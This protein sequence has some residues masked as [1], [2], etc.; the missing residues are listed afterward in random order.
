[1]TEWNVNFKEVNTVAEKSEFGKIPV[2]GFDFYVYE[3][4]MPDVLPT[5][6]VVMLINMDKTPEGLT[7]VQGAEVNAPSVDRPFNLSFTEYAH[8][9]TQY[10]NPERIE[11]TKYTKVLNYEGFTPLLYCNGDPVLFVKEADGQKIVMMNFSVNYSMI[12]MYVEFPILMYNIIEYFMPA[13]LS[14]HAYDI[15]QTISLNARSDELTIESVDGS[16]EKTTFKEFPQEIVLTNPGTYTLSQMPISGIPQVEQFFV[17]IPA[18][19]S[20]ICPIEEELYELIVPKKK[21]VA[22]YDLLLYFAAALVALVFI[23]RFLHSIDG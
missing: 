22:D 16:I 1:M 5:D 18:T 2:E 3:G 15:N 8:P 17:K 13:T 12:S 6:G 7:A 21:D 10:L 14:A 9:I 4:T 20:N 11:V 23:E 19:Q